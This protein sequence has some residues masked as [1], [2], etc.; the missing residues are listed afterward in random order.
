[1]KLNL[2]SNKVDVIINSQS[3]NELLLTKD[4]ITQF[5]NMKVNFNNNY[6]TSKWDIYRSLL[7]RYENVGNK[8]KREGKISRAYYKLKEMMLDDKK[9]YTKIK[10]V[11][12]LAEGPGGFIKFL[13]DYYKDIEVYGIT[14]KYTNISENRNMEKFLNENNNVQIIY[15][16]E[17]NPSHD[18]NLYNKD[19]VNAF[20]ERVGKV[21]LV[22][23]DGGFLAKD[24]NNKEVEH[25]KLFLAE[26]LTAF[27]IL[28]KG[29]SFILKIYDIF[30][31]PTLELLF[32]L[33]NTF[34]TVELKKPVTSR[35]ANSER[36]VICHGFKGY[37]TDMH[38]EEKDE[39]YSSILDLSKVEQKKFELFVGN[40]ER[41]NKNYVDQIINN[42]NEI[43]N[44][45]EVNDNNR[46]ERTKKEKE[47]EIFKGVW[48]KVYEKDD[49]SEKRQE[50]RKLRVVKKQGLNTDA[51]EFKM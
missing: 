25:L 3:K 37:D 49:R 7:N 41:E 15:G 4:K 32:L 43:V 47:Q 17:N 11:A 50:K 40:L 21:D 38:V 46:S 35:P 39:D 26:T 10:K 20:A 28:N 9:K 22:T 5:Y 31:Q 24:E 33:A 19:V 12:T 51:T 30:T 23:A 29:G 44:Y 27:K 16:E 8:A 45:I 18:G 6:Q 13:I 2:Q 48:K 34:K 42:I 1:M 36:Y 14:L